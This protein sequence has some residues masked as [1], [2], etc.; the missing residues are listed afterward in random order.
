MKTPD[1]SPF[2]IYTVMAVMSA[3]ALVLIGQLVRW[4]VIEHHQFTV[5]AA[6]EHQDELVIPPRRGEIRD[7][8]GHLLAVDIIEYDLSASP[9]IISDPEA[10]A[11]RL[12]RLLDLPRPELLQRLTGDT[13]WTPIA[14]NLPQSAAE[15]LADWDIVGLQ[16]EPQARRVYPEGDL[17]AHLLGFVNSNGNGFYGVEGYYD[18]ILRGKA[19][20]QT[21]ERSPF[22]EM[23]PLGASHF[24]PPVSGGTFFLTIDRN[25]QYLIE[26]EL[27]K[28]VR[29]YGAQRGSVVVMEPKTGAVLGMASYPSYD[30]NNYSASNERLFFD[31]DVS[32]QYEPG[33]V[34]KIITMAAGLDAGV[35]GPFTVVYDG[36]S[37]EVGGR[38]IYNW[39]RQSHGNV[40]MTDVLAKSLNVG[41]AQVATALGKDRFYTY[42]KRFGFGRLTEIDL[43]SEGP[44][45][46]KT[47]K[48]ASWHESDLGTNSFG[49]G[50]AVTPIQI[51]TAVGAIANKGLLMKP[52]VVQRI[53]E[54]EREIEVKP[55]VVRR[56]VSE[57]TAATLTD[58]LVEAQ[59]QANAEALLAGYRVAGKTGTAEIPI[60]GGYHP[61]LT[62]ASFVGFLPADDPQVLVLVII[63]RPTSSRWGNQTASPTFK[64]IAEQLVVLLDLPP[65]NIRLAQSQ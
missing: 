33:S 34:F 1:T 40:D 50:I 56:A 7:R 5:L 48:E 20:I 37:I 59:E 62:L 26:D 27:E 36:G 39:D 8:Y 15:T 61:T 52:H 44:G 3:A 43:G 35:V 14:H 28:A 23:I 30:P 24:V 18:S 51:A 11:D 53:L 41:I 29:N 10:T 21:G 19:G 42:V 9:Q 58:M 55:S 22:G 47:P 38:V 25:V 4:Q 31:P 64:R 2:R 63:D 6:E 13:T 46:L 32:E 60:P 16:L 65:D 12:A 57:E 49:Q 54:G 45:T 17:A